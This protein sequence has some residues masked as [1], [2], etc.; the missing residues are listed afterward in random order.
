MI[1]LADLLIGYTHVMTTRAFLQ[2]MCKI[3][4]PC[5]A[6]PPP[7]RSP[8]PLTTHITWRSLANFKLFCRKMSSQSSLIFSS[9]GNQSFCC[10]VPTT[11]ILQS[12]AQGTLTCCRVSSCGPQMSLCTNGFG[13]R[14]PRMSRI[15]ASQRRVCTCG[16]GNGNRIQRT[17]SGCLRTTVLRLRRRTG[18]STFMLPKV[19]LLQEVTCSLRDRKG[20]ITSALG[21]EQPARL[22]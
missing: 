16:C 9:P 3:Y 20:Y 19:R 8:L 4:M 10:P 1:V 7:K 11:R 6:C 2:D 14:R 17:R 15:P 5:T 18:I 13:S 12:G 21:S 22:H